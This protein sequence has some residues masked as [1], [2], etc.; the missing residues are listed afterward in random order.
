VKRSNEKKEQEVTKRKPGRPKGV[1]DASRS[2]PIDKIMKEA[3]YLGE[4]SKYNK[5]LTQVRCGATPRIAFLQLGFSQHTFDT[6]ILN[7]T[8]GDKGELYERFFLDTQQAMSVAYADCEGQVARKTGK[9][10]LQNS[11]AAR[12]LGNEDWRDDTTRKVETTSVNSNVLNVNMVGFT[13]ALQL[14]E[15]NGIPLNNIRDYNPN[16]IVDVDLVESNTFSGSDNSLSHIP[17]YMRDSLSDSNLSPI[18][19]DNNLSP[20]PNDNNVPPLVTT[21]RHDNNLSPLVTIPCH[22]NNL[23]VTTTCHDNNLSAGTPG[24]DSPSSRAQSVGSHT[25]PKYNKEDTYSP[26]DRPNS[27]DSIMDRLSALKKSIEG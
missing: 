18:V 5:Y 25:P 13:E 26:V 9:D 17:N 22:D 23:S 11:P 24:E 12:Y 16:D 1:K 4:E 14:L 2:V 20:L 8:K 27:L 19:S 15:D 6:W 21:T 3:D 10:W 7:G